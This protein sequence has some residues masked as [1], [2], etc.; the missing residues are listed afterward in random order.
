MTP[1]AEQATIPSFLNLPCPEMKI[2]PVYTVIAEKFQAMVTLDIANSRLKDFY[3]IW[4]IAANMEL[5]GRLLKDAINATFTLR[6][7][8]LDAHPLTIFGD[9]FKKDGS[10]Q[11][12]WMAFLNKNDLK[13]DH[14]FFE[15]MD[16]LQCLLEPVYQA[17]ALESDFTKCWG[18]ADWK[19][20]EL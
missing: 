20:I 2:Y 12:Q 8:S 5:D 1:E 18:R 4:V 3:D 16:L 19:W 14:S 10:K 9:D 7:T 17:T 6:G 11:K 15:L 13:S